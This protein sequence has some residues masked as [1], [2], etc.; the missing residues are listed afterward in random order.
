MPVHAVPGGVIA[1]VRPSNR[2]PAP[3]PR[4]AVLIL[5]TMVI[6]GLVMFHVTT[7]GQVP[8][9][10]PPMLHGSASAVTEN[11][12]LSVRGQHFTPG[13]QVFIAVQDMW[14]VTVLESRWT[15]A[16]PARV[17]GT[18][19]SAGGTI[20]ETFSRLCGH[21]VM[22]R[23]LDADTGVMSNALEDTLTCGD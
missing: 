7:A 8:E 17:T 23:A 14:G 10:V 3:L 15:T 13:G 21:S 1:D 19:V 18:G 16:S 2:T 4:Q 12:T 11:R 5:V 22:V 9:S 20:H 6:L